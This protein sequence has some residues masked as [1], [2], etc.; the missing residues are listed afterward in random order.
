MSVRKRILPSGE[1]RWQVDY[2]DQDGKRRH[3]QFET[4]GEAVGYETKVRG[5]IVAGTHVADGASITVGEGA[6]LWIQRAE[7]DAL[8]ASTVRQYRQH[9]DLHIK[10]L[11][12]QKKLSQLTRPAIEAFKDKLLETRSRALARAVLAS[13]KG[14]LKEAQRRGLV[15]Q[16]VASDVQVRI[17]S[18]DEEEVVIPTK[19]H[20]RALLNK[21]AELWPLTRVHTNHKGERV[22]TP[23]AWRPLIVT[24]IFTGL[25]SSEL[26]GLTW[27]SVD[28]GAGVIRVRQRA[29]LRNVMGPTKSKAGRRDVP[30]SPMVSNT[31]KAWKLACPVTTLDLVFP[32]EGKTVVTN[33]TIHR[34]CWGPLQKACGMVERVPQIDADGAPVIDEA[35]EAVVDHIPLYTFHALRHAAASLFI[36]QGWSPKKVQTVMGHSTIQ[37]TFDTYGH[38]WP[39]LE[40]DKAALAQIEARLGFPN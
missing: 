15:G 36:E 20:I 3:K 2:R 39:N 14:I 28:F 37:V 35:G 24:A 32:A 34:S 38:L 6:V 40:D 25:R 9:V 23:I 18:R 27:E 21:A 10:P 31:L 22:V 8:E 4:K 29:D 13:L 12:G 26:R 11:L 7:L 1:T 16:N 5:E 33:G 17:S 19:E 30:M